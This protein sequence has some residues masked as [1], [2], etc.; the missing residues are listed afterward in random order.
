ML[1]SWY[2]Q[3]IGSAVSMELMYAGWMGPMR[4]LDL[5]PGLSP[6]S[7]GSEATRWSS[8]N[9]TLPSSICNSG[10][11]YLSNTPNPPP[12]SAVGSYCEVGYSSSF[13]IRITSQDAR[14]VVG[15][16]PPYFSITGQKQGDEIDVSKPAAGSAYVLSYTSVEVVWTHPRNYRASAQLF[17]GESHRVPP[18]GTPLTPPNLQLDPWAT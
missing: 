9:V 7:Y 2:T 14:G 4:I 16:S 3:G 6:T 12:G 5:T 15:A 11:P 1:V 18:R 13:F 17:F 8:A 10:G